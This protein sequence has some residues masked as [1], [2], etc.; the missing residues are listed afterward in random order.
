MEIQ[1]KSKIKLLNIFLALH[2]A[3]KIGNEPIMLEVASGVK[4]NLDI[5]NK[6][7]ITPR[8]WMKQSFPKVFLV[9]TQPKS[10]WVQSEPLLQ[11]KLQR[12]KFEIIESESRTNSKIIR[13]VDK[14]QKGE[15]DDTINH[16]GALH[17]AWNNFTSWD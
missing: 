17:D 6:E 7:K 5:K 11:E 1:V 10:H 8:K 12:V 13:A 3:I 2:L 4:V 16:F 15:F 9:A 14:M